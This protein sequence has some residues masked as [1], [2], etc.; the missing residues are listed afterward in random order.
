VDEPAIARYLV[1]RNRDLVGCKTGLDPTGVPFLISDI[2]LSSIEHE[3]AARRLTL[4]AECL[5]ELRPIHGLHDPGV[6]NLYHHITNHQQGDI[7]HG[8]IA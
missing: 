2:L 5:G 1:R 6:R 4:F 8:Y 7:Q 3:G